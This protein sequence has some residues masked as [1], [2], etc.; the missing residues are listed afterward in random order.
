M[1]AGRVAVAV[2]FSCMAAGAAAAPK[3]GPAT[4][5]GGADPNEVIC[6]KVEITGSRLAVKR[7]CLTRAEWADRRLQDRNATEK[8]QI[9]GPMKQD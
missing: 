3:S 4:A 1:L 7:V 6:E 5:A 2:C 8:M 9:L